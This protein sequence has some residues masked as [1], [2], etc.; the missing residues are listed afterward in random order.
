MRNVFARVSLFAVLTALGMAGA[1][2][3][4]GTWKLNMEKS[5]VM[6]GPT[7][8][9]SLTTTREAVEGGV[10]LTATGTRADGALNSSYTAKYDG[11]SY[12]VT[13]APWDTISIKQLD[14]NT[15]AVINTKT[16][17]KYKTTGRTVVSKDGKT[18]TNTAKGTDN[19][20]K[21]MHQIL[22]FEKQ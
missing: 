5:K 18:M 13:G 19:E 11:K 7:A 3:T 9:K 21:A 8:I 1:D 17:G 16:G 2:N 6:V 14:A 4:I 10:K 22:V 20:G 15:L 12:P